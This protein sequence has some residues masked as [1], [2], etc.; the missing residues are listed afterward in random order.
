MKQLKTKAVRIYGVSDLRLEEFDLP[1][2]GDDEIQ[3]KIITDSL[4]MST[5]KVSKQGAKHKKLPDNLA[6]IAGIHMR[7]PEA[8]LKELGDL[9]DPPVGKSGVNH[10]LR[11]LKEIADRLR[12]DKE[13]GE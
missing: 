7:Y 2:M 11:R 1:E 5:Y 3:A 4:C 10:R 12:Q 6:E 8:T 13:Q 9:L